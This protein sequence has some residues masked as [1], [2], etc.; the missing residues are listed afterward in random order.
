MGP[1]PG[2]AAPGRL[3]ARSSRRRALLFRQQR[4]EGGTCSGAPHARTPASRDGVK[5]YKQ[6][7][8]MEPKGPRGVAGQPSE[9]ARPLLGEDTDRKSCLTSS[10]AS[11]LLFFNWVLFCSP[12]KTRGL[13]QKASPCHQT[14]AASWCQGS[15][16]YTTPGSTTQCPPCLQPPDSPPRRLSAAPR[17]ACNL[18]LILAC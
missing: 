18:T 14:I 7:A 6:H 16:Q 2:A 12:H 13:S 15:P 10:N 11:S 4:A 5:S 3:R 17:A 9:G 8:E 1:T